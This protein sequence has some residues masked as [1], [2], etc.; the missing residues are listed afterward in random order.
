M[1]AW[2]SA[3]RVLELQAGAGDHDKVAVGRFGPEEA[4]DG[5]LALPGT[6]QYTPAVIAIQIWYQHPTIVFLSLLTCW[7]LSG[8]LSGTTTIARLHFAGLSR[9]DKA[10]IA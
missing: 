2:R 4:D 5:A 6:L 1:P 10:I 9:A 8:L 3:A 7:L